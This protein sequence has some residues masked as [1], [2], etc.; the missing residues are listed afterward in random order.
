MSQ[1]A[2]FFLFIKVTKYNQAMKTETLL[3]QIIRIS[4]TKY[5]HFSD[6]LKF[7]MALRGY[8][9]QKLANRIYLTHSTISGYRTGERMPSCEIIC[10]IATELDVSTDF[11]LGLVDYICVK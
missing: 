11:L 8:S 3:I 5:P 6:R 10:R 9:S 1:N 4:A 7:A 2:T